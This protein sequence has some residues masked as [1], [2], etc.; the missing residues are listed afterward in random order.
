VIERGSSYLVAASNCGNDLECNDNNP[1][2]DDRCAQGHCQRT[3][4]NGP[5]DDGLFCNGSDTCTEGWCATH[6]RN[7]CGDGAACDELN[8]S[9][10]E[11]CSYDLDCDDGEPCTLDSCVGGVCSHAVQSTCDDGLFCN[12]ADSCVAGA[13]TGHAGTPCGAA[14]PSSGAA[15]PMTCD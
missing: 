7:P 2:T 14:S 5:C 10:T 8:D 4:L 15:R 1:C 12:G 11:T 6:G 9:C 13:Y 3:S